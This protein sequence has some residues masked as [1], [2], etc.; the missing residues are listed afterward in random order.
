MTSS[1]ILQALASPMTRDRPNEAFFE[2]NYWD[3]LGGRSR[4]DIEARSVRPMLV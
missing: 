3:S 1:L 2:Q 4:I